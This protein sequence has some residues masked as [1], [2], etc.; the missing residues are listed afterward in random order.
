MSAQVQTAPGGRIGWV[1]TAKGI[2]IFLVVMMHSTLGV[3]AAAGQTG[4]LGAVTD[5]AKPFRMPD[6]FLLAALFLAS[7][8]DVPWRLY[9]DRKVLHFVYFYLLWLAIQC[10]IKCMLVYGY[11]VPETLQHLAWSLIEPFGILWFIYLLAIFFMVTR[12]TRHLPVWL[13]LGAAA[14]LKAAPIA[15][16]WSV[17]DQFAAHYVYFYAGYALA[18]PIFAFADAAASRASSAIENLAA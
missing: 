15:T 13:M 12:L 9:L 7:R 2:C 4:W 14:A 5:F 3:E 8:I 10:L 17:I 11:S 18:R 1:D 16:G 6:F